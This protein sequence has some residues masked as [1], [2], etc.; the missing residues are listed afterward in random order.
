MSTEITRPHYN[1]NP[2][3]DQVLAKKVCYD[4]SKNDVVCKT[5]VFLN[6]TFLF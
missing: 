2:Q 6:I 1:G 4:K 5:S 3:T